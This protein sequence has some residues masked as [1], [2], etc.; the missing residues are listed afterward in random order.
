VKQVLVTIDRRGA[1]CPPKHSP[2]GTTYKCLAYSA[3]LGKPRSDGK[4]PWHLRVPNFRKNHPPGNYIARVYGADAAG[5]TE[6]KV[7]R[8]NRAAFKVR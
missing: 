4:V 8:T 6:T 3:D 2:P 5:N 7:R 1:A